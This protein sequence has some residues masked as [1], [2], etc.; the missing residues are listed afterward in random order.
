M[1]GINLSEWLL[2]IVVAL[3]VI[4][5]KELPVVLKH[6]M[7]LVHELR[8]LT[9]GFRAQFH[10]VMRESGMEDVARD[11]QDIHR[12]TTTIIDLEGNPQEAHDVRDLKQLAAPPQTTP[13]D[14]A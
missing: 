10:E 6:V 9:H 11:M 8:A 14:E 13:K 7:R 3:V 4:G 1:L 2:I 5:P 12:R